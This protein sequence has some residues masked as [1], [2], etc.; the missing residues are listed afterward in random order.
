MLQI[1][2]V[3]TNATEMVGDIKYDVNYTVSNGALNT[4]SCAVYRVTAGSE[5]PEGVITPESTTYL[6]HM[7]KDQNN[8]TANFSASESAANHMVKFSSIL[9][10]IE[11]SLIV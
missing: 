8:Q 3:E 10:E 4:V 11:L 9:D 7:S 5:S 1:Q 2:K 6:G